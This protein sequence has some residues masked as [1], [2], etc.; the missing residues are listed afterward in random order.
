MPDRPETAYISKSKFLNGLQ[1]PKL[2]WTYYNKHMLIPEPDAG[3]QHIFD[4][5]HVVGDL[6]KQL[7]PG[8]IEV[9]MTH[10][11]DAL[12]LTVTATRDLLKRRVPI[13][14]ASFLEDG[15]YCRVDVLV[16]VP[17]DDGDPRSGDTWDLVEVKSSTKVKDVN[18]H[19]VAFQHD[20]LTRAGVELN[21]LYVM[22]ID[23]SYT[24]GRTFDVGLFF[25]LTDVTERALALKDYIP[26]AIDTMFETVD[27]PDPDTPIGPRCKK[28]YTCPL[29][30]HCW[31]AL[32]DDNVTDLYYAG[33]RAFD[34]LDEGIFTISQVPESRLSPQQ[35][36]QK[37][38]LVTGEL[39]IDKGAVK[40]WLDGLEYPLYHLDFETMNPAMPEITGTRPYQRIPFQFSLHIQEAPGASPKHHEFLATFSDDPLPGDPRPA[41]VESLLDLIGGEGTVLAWNMAFERSVLEDLGEVLP[42]RAKELSKVAERLDD[43]MI[44][45]RS[46]WVHHPDQKGSCSLKSVLPAMTDLGYDKLQINDGNAAGREYARV[47]YEHM[48]IED[49]VGILIALREYCRLDTLAMVE[50]LG[51]LEGLVG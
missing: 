28:P 17:G 21:R 41:L 6:A 20:A 2:L 44:P 46:F 4:T 24:R 12:E 5:G 39:Q 22:H 32:P 37:K 25:S 18:I 1:C 47:L 23:N 10:G 26:K 35:I 38:A 3:Q 49:R 31:G 30:P 11:K 36:I 15:R 43:L 13:F 19:D 8:G 14:E 27:G 34:L 9:P 7:Y 16:P 50:I 45:F 48:D 33:R 51:K 42:T 29:I 40:D